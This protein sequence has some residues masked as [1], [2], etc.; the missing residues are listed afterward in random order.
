MYDRAA[1]VP[2][3]RQ[4]QTAA[5]PEGL[6]VQES[7]VLPQMSSVNKART[8][9]GLLLSDGFVR[10]QTDSRSGRCYFRC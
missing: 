10:V 7:I 9:R 3:R 2:G 5:Q 6:C 4:G 8:Q 1:D